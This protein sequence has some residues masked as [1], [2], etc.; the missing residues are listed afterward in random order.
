MKPG[1]YS[2]R[3]DLL[4]ILI[5][6]REHEITAWI[7]GWHANDYSEH[8]RD[9]VDILQ[10]GKPRIKDLLPG[11]LSFLGKLEPRGSEATALVEIKDWLKKEDLPRT[12]RVYLHAARIAINIYGAERYARAVNARAQR[13]SPEGGSGVLIGQ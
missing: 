9:V 11:L 4:E 1:T 5:G 3:N 12:Q 13:E 8:D 2:Y 7:V 6:G 10:S